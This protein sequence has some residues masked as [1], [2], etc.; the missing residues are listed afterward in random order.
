[1]KRLSLTDWSSI[2]EI[3]GTMAVVISLLFVAFTIQRNTIALSG[4]A[5]DEMFDRINNFQLLIVSNP[6]LHAVYIKGRDDF[7]NLTLFEREQ[8]DMLITPV[9]DLW[10]RAIQR[11]HE[12]II[13]S[14][15]ID[16]WHN[17]FE[18]YF[19]LHL[20]ITFWN[21]IKWG[22]PDPVFQARM[23]AALTNASKPATDDANK[24]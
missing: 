7:E 12:G 4:D 22:W 24:E 2:A 10:N 5:E 17:W 16:D 1:M 19:R 8:Y 14:G 18:N 13:Q 23:E 3:T 21:E 9:I 6:D 20:D 15:S 11:E